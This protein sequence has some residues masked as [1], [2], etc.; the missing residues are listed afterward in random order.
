[1][2]HRSYG[3]DEVC[4]ST[5][6]CRWY[7]S[8]RVRSGLRPTSTL[9]LAGAYVSEFFRT[10]N[11]G[12]RLRAKDKGLIGTRLRAEDKEDGLVCAPKDKEDGLVCAPKTKKMDWFARRKANKMD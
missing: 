9:A 12:M 1:V 3:N 5:V 6:S 8:G 4:S 11:F 7:R 2:T 10:E